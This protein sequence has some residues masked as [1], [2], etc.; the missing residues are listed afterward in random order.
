M[1]IHAEKK[2]HFK[3]LTT[4]KYIFKL[5]LW[6]TSQILHYHSHLSEVSMAYFCRPHVAECA[7]LWAV[8]ISIPCIF[9][10]LSRC[11]ITADALQVQSTLCGHHL[12]L[13]RSI[14]TILAS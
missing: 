14:T 7:K 2:F 12:R 4:A 10:G 11:T 1:K 5:P 6:N 3:Q 9:N 8:K 13:S